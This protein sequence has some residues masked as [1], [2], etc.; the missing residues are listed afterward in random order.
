M[1]I[2]HLR[3]EQIPAVKQMIIT[4]WNEVCDLDRTVVG[5]EAISKLVHEQ[6]P[7]LINAKF[8]Y[9]TYHFAHMVGYAMPLHNFPNIDNS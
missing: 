9:S 3:Y 5:W 2:K 4:A 8:S 6:T 7:L 1:A